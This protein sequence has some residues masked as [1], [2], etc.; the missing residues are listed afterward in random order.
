GQMVRRFVEIPEHLRVRAPACSVSWQQVW[1]FFV[2]QLGLAAHLR[3]ALDDDRPAVLAAA[4]A[5][6]AAVLAPS[7]SELLS[8]EL[9]DCC[10]ATGWPAPPTGYLTRPAT[11]A[12]WEAQPPQQPPP[13]SSAAAAAAAAAADAP[14]A[15]EDVALVDPLA[16]ALQMGLLQRARYLLTARHAPGALLPLLA[17]LCG[18]A[19]SGSEAALAVAREPGLLAALG[20]LLDPAAAVAT[21]AAG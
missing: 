14:D 2:S 16:G 6:L 3:L 18:V 19:R 7:E 5:A 11:A 1:Q 20:A 10:P 17:V 8:T 21:A 4:A 13:P 12:T 9:A 15:P